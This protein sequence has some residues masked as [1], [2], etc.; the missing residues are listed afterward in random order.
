MAN[1]VTR[2]TFVDVTIGLAVLVA[3]GNGHIRGFWP[4]FGQYAG[5]V[6]GVLS[7]AVLAPTLN[8][9]F[10]ITGSLPRS[11]A[12][13]AALVV[14]GAVGSTIGFALG[15]P[16][17]RRILSR[18]RA[19]RLDSTMGMLFSGLAVLSVAWFLGLTF[20]RGPSVD[21][22][23]AIQRSVILHAL[24]S[25]APRPP[26]FLARVERILAGVPFPQVFSS[27]EPLLPEAPQPVPVSL[28]TPG[29]RRAKDATLKV[30]GRGCGGVVSG[31]G[32][33]VAP[34]EVLTNAHVVAGTSGLLV[35]TPSG[36]AARA[37]VVLFDPELDVAILRVTGLPL[38]P[39]PMADAGRGTPGAVIGYPGGG[40]ETVVPAVVNSGIRAIGR[41]IYGENQ[42]VRQ[43]WV[44]QATVQPGNSGGPLVDRDGNV[45]GVVF[46]A[47]TT[48]PDTGYA[49][50]DAE[51]A[52]DIQLAQ[53][54]TQAV[55][56]GRCAA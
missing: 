46:A 3:L 41:D 4:S 1:G 52:A 23:R 54:Q 9:L 11:L 53:G 8:D 18:P 48:R 50:V 36:R 47:S 29:I 56:V 22:A 16:I 38:A 15:A 10:G 32:F 42:V 37:T 51:A 34:D 5:M 44:I 13:V 6:G 39:L 30:R 26:A 21:L 31:S 33:P 19:R 25:V 14:F 49:L 28:D 43:I 40:P 55:S 45:I 12:A 20:G 2:F 24:D 7:G 35:L 27:L 17:R